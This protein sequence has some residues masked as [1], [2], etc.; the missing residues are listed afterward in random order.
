M[1]T[2]PVIVSLL[3]VGC[4]NTDTTVGG[5][6]IC[7]AE[8]K[9][10]EARV[11]PNG[12]SAVRARAEQA[13]LADCKFEEGRPLI[14]RWDLPSVESPPPPPRPDYVPVPSALLPP[15]PAP[16]NVPPTAL[17]NNRVAGTKTVLPDVET[18]LEIQRAGKDKIIGAYKMCIT[19]SGE[20]ST[21]SIL[22][23]TS[24]ADYDQKIMRE[25][26]EWKYL[27]YI[28]NGTETPVCTAVTFIWSVP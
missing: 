3:L 11:P 4:S 28:Y 14:A 24:F 12:L 8:G 19:V 25:M 18:Q 2:R 15:P 23:S 1:R 16:M 9:T 7:S 22:K 5:R 17:E 26:R 13:Q 21:V 27:P 20:V 10:F 6:L